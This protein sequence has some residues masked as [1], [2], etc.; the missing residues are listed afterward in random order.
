LNITGKTNG[1]YTYRIAA[2]FNNPN[3][4]EAGTT[5]VGPYSNLKCVT[6][7]GVAPTPT[8]TPTPTDDRYHGCGLRHH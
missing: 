3:P 5:V 8:P 1:T 2:L 7:S 4:L 6:V